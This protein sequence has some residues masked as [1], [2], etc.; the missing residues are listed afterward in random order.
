MIAGAYGTTRGSDSTFVALVR[1]LQPTVV[2]ANADGT[3]S[4]APIGQNETFE[5][6]SPFLWRQ[7]HGHD[8]LQASVENGV[9]TR[10]ST[11]SAA[12]IFVFVRQ[13]GLAGTGLELPL[14][15]A[16][17][18]VLALIALLWPVGALVRWRYRAPF[19]HTGQRA[20]AYRLVRLAAI[21]AVAAVALWAVVLDQVSSTTGAPVEGLLHAA[22][23]LTLVGFVGGVVAALCNLA[24]TLAPSAR[25]SA[26]LFAVLALAAFAMMLWIAASYGLLGFSG[27]Y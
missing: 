5:E 6:V 13:G 12:P 22:Q 21:V 1:L 11:D 8:R 19:P 14:A 23:L 18:G 9:V 26:R 15:E 16:A 27:E 4:A 17:L 24:L 2:T 25:W 7:V 20:M 10:W 3:I